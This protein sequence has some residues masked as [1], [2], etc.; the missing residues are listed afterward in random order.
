MK[1]HSR[2]EMNLVDGDTKTLIKKFILY[3]LPLIVVGVLELLY[4]SFDLIVVQQKEGVLAGA[5]VGSNSSLISLLTNGFIGLSVGVNV[6]VANY[7]GKNDRESASKVMHTGLL[8]SFIVGVVFAIVC[9]FLTDNIVVWMGV[10]ESFRELSS[11]YLSIYFL[12]IPFMIVYNFGAAS[13]RGIGDSTKPLIFLFLSG[14]LNIALNYVFVFG[15]SLGVRGV[16]IATVISQAVSSILVVIFLYINKGFIRLRFRDLKLDR[17]ML[18]KI[19]Q[20]GVPSGIHSIIFSITNVILQATVNTWPVE[21][22]TANGDAANIEA[23]TYIMMYG[24]SNATI[25]F[26]S[27]NYGRGYYKNI[28]KIEIIS[29]VMVTII[30]L[31]MGG[32]TLALARPLLH[33]Y[34]GANY[35]EQVATYA[36]ERM[37]IVLLTYFLCGY[38][39]VQCAVLRGLEHPFA[40]T[41]CALVGCCLFRVFW[42]YVIYSPI[43]GAATHSLAILYMCY[44][45]SWILVFALELGIY[46]FLKKKIKA[47]CEE[48]YLEYE[49]KH[50]QLKSA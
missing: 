38:L 22:V 27:A 42:N 43:E 5:A 40:P 16:A 30:G 33:V 44:P 29:L 19:L 31:A 32:L 12:S 14:V 50:P 21:V 49:K 48:N 41:I 1:K 39:D 8:G 23:Y 15:G 10:S 6:L 36:V 28:R 17:E 13:F 45:I 24:V 25:A 4:N 20:V 9:F 34:M 26:I 11:Q 35:S 3:S 7:Y 47:K 46:L 18:F 2:L 37:T